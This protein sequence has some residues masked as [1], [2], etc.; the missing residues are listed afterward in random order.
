MKAL[1]FPCIRPADNRVID[2]L[3]HMGEILADGNGIQRGLTEGLLLKDPGAAYYL[4]E[5]RDDNGAQTAI[6][7]NVPVE[8]VA[9]ALEDAGTENVD[10]DAA[11][12]PGVAS[13]DDILDLKVQP[14]PTSL[15]YQA[16]PVMQVIIGAAKEGAALFD[17][18]DPSGAKHRFWE[19]KRSDAVDAI[20]A[21][22]EQAPAPHMA[23]DQ[24]QAAFAVAAAHRLIE[25]A[26]TASTYTGKEPFNFILSALFADDG[27]GPSPAPRVPL[28]LMMHQ[29]DRM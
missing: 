3:S 7:A 17:L 9:K 23:G 12:S 24:E 18:V 5:R 26:R 27:T 25:R 8:D 2:A 19:V 15:S 20:R 6:L 13:A 29:V 14:R 22:L 28:G 4:Y 10:G 21:M 1:P 11:P 16:S